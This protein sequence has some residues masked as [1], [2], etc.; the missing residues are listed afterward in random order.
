MLQNTA[1]NPIREAI[2]I[3]GIIVIIS[4]PT[5]GVPSDL[6][7]DIQ[8]PVSRF[9]ILEEYKGEA[10]LDAETQ[11]I[12]ERSPS[13]AET[14]WANAS[15]RC[16]FTATGGRLGWRL[17][18]FFE[19]MTLVEPGPPTAASKPSLPP[20]HPFRGVKADPYWTTSSQDS[21]PTNAYAV[22]F[23]RGDVTLQR[24]NQA[25]AWWCVRGRTSNAPTMTTSRGVQE[26][27]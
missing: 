14:A 13:S 6:T 16:A 26:P 20:G 21:E 2:G 4:V 23:L 17:P 5:I 15:L 9:Q 1:L 3:L 24:K 8:S 19:L 25:H 7:S 18:S 22:D 12:W 11:L 10:V 27:I